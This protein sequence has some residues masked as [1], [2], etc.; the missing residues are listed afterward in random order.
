MTL[1]RETPPAALSTLERRELLATMPNPGERYDYM[2]ALEGTFTIDAA[3]RVTVAL[4]YVADRHVLSVDGFSAYLAALNG[5]A[6]P[7]LEA[8]A[9]TMLGDV[10]NELIPRWAQIHLAVGAGDKAE[11]HSVIIEDHQPG[12][13]NPTLLARHGAP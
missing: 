6:W 3:Q 13:D 4:H 10:N 2:V 12:W 8:A 5:G 7:N 11:R 1:P 9:L